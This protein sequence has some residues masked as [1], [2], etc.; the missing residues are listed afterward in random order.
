MSLPDLPKQHKKVEADF[1]VRFR[2]WLKE[3]PQWS[4]APELKQTATDS[5][6][7]SCVADKQ[8]NYLLAIK[9]DKGTLIRIQGTNGEPDYV[10]LRSF[11]AYVVIKFP[12][13][14]C[15]IDIEDFVAEKVNS[16]RKSLT[17]E[18]AKVIAKTYVTLK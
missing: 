12:K 2:R 4:H 13:F 10:Y 3:N 16:K 18:R 7:F 8:I 1:G 15:L 11:P 6:S 17:S 9:S 5:I 14:F